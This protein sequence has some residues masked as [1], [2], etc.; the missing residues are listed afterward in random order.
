M[1]LLIG[2]HVD[3]PGLFVDAES[4]RIFIIRTG[5]APVIGIFLFIDRQRL[6]IKHDIR[7]RRCVDFGRL[8]IGTGRGLRRR[9]RRLGILFR[10]RNLGV[11]FGLQRIALRALAQKLGQGNLNLTPEIGFA[12]RRCLERGAGICAIPG[13]NAGIVSDAA[14]AFAYVTQV[15]DLVRFVV[16]RIHLDPEDFVLELIPQSGNLRNALDHQIKRLFACG[17]DD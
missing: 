14:R 6:N 9:S 13:N 7:R 2:V 16:W 4:R 1:A 15:I 8:A 10:C 17:K 3:D 12:L 5:S 11:F